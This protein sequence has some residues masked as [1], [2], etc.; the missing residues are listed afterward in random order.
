MR[1]QPEWGAWFAELAAAGRAARL[2]AGLWCATER[3]PLLAGL[4]P[5]EWTFAMAPLPRVKPMDA[6]TMAAEMLRGHLDV[7]GPSTVREL[8]RAID[9]DGAAVSLA[10]IR[11]ET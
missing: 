10:L 5:A 2:P 9:L 4:Y 1:P 8:A 7:S 6:E 3:V 11:L